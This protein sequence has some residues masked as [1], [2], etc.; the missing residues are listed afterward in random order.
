MRN[1]NSKKSFKLI[2]LLVTVLFITFQ[3]GSV[4]ADNMSGG[5][6]TLQA[7][8][9]HDGTMFISGNNI[10]IKGT[11]DG[12]AF[13]AGQNINI[14]GVI[15]GDL[16]IA[17]QNVKVNGTVNGSIITASQDTI[18]DGNITNNIYS[19]SQNTTIKSQTK[20][21]VFLAGDKIILEDKTRIEKD[22][23]VGASQIFQ[24]G[25]ISG[26]FLAASENT[27]ISGLIGKNARIKT[28]D[29]Y[30]EEAEIR[31]NLKYDSVDKAIISKDSKIAGKTD[32]NKIEPQPKA[33]VF[34]LAVLMSIVIKIINALVIWFIIKLLRPRFWSNLARNIRLNPLKSLGFGALALIVTPTAIFFLILAVVMYPL[35]F[36]LTALYALAIYLSRVIVSVFIGEWLQ[37]K[38]AWTYKHKGVWTTLLGLVI[39]S[40]L[41]VIPI[42]GMIVNT[43]VILAG[44]GSIVFYV[45]Q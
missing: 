45:K 17:G 15:N 35:A 2:L 3:F 25:E 43:L 6:F 37:D 21:A 30:V 24:A 28:K 7:D 26:N 31:G 44:L 20:G 8:K 42:V 38:F 18:L 5:D 33:S 11:V 16:F 39:V 13:I 41:G 40:T 32:W 4:L 34:S 1:L 10:N 14:S 19:A 9:T 22:L 23:F 27:S 29:L 12:T 36:L